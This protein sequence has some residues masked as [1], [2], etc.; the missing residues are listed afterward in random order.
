[1]SELINKFKGKKYYIKLNLHKIYNLIYIKN[2]EEWKT[3]FQT[4][5][6]YYKYTIMLFK[7]INISAII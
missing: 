2:K 7:L 1:M 6:K 4:K 5:Y 3:T